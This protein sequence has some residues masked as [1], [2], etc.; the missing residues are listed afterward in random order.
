MDR[1]PEKT[2][3]RS[4]GGAADASEAGFKDGIPTLTIR[5]SEQA[6]PR[7]VAVR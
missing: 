3:D 1:S 5:R 4:G 7:S 6:K 2:T